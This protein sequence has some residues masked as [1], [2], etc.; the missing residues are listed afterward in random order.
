MS[1]LA[2]LVEVALNPEAAK[3]FLASIASVLAA[4]KSWVE[5]K[6]R[7]AARNAGKVAESL[8]LADP[9][10]EVRANELI[11]VV[12]ADTLYKLTARYSKCFDRFNRM[13][14]EEDERSFPGDIEAAADHALPNCVCEALSTLRKVAGDLNDPIL[15]EA[16][17]RFG[18]ERRHGE[19]P[20][21]GP[22]RRR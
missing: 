12:P 16:W 5:L 17:E 1:T 4:T 7:A 9:E 15:E 2:P 3:N 20:Q 14:D 6:D 10:T 19:R 22:S 18:C 21:R 13:L 11:E 8:A